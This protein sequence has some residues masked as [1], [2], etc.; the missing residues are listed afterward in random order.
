MLDT[1]YSTGAQICFVLLGLW[2]IVVQFK[3]DLFVR[4]PQRRRTAY[5]ISLY[6]ILPGAMSLL[7]LLASEL[8]ILWRIAFFGAAAL[9]AFETGRVLRAKTQGGG[10]AFGR[11]S[12]LGA[13]VIYVL[14]ALIALA[15]GLL[16]A[17]GIT[18]LLLE[19]A[20]LALL[21]FLGVHLAWTFFMELPTN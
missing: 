17:A 16:S 21:I 18:P 9:G 15:P 4:E 2:W 14:I 13:L 10:R 6:F 1:F 20:L 11:N 3:Y 8:T 5:N 19:G 7:S 12:N